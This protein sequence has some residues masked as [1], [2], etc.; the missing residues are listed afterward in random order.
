MIT[1]TKEHLNQRG[2]EE[3]CTHLV[4]FL[5][6]RHDGVDLPCPETDMETVEGRVT[7]NTFDFLMKGKHRPMIAAHIIDYIMHRKLKQTQ[8]CPRLKMA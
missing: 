7:D 8:A 4:C 2:A 6:I 1:L 3:D 5:K